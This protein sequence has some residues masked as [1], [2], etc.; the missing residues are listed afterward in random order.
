MWTDSLLRG[1]TQTCSLTHTHIT[2]APLRSIVN[3]CVNAIWTTT[4]SFKPPSGLFSPVAFHSSPET[5]DILL[6]TCA[7]SAIHLTLT[8]HTL[9][10]PPSLISPFA[11]E[12]NNSVCWIMLCEEKQ[13]S[14]SK[15]SCHRSCH[16]ALRQSRGYG[17]TSP[18]VALWCVLQFSVFLMFSC[19]VFLVLHKHLQ[20]WR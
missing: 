16:R 17:P 4:D 7:Q 10:K 9:S 12:A 18:P 20:H 1:H 14:L 15:P 6:C 3:V 11:L 19:N 13:P 8:L 5:S 2:T